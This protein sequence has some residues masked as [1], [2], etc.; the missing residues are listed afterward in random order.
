MTIK[1]QLEIEERSPGDVRITLQAPPAD[2][3]ETDNETKIL[4]AFMALGECL[5]DPEVSPKLG[6][7][8]TP[9]IHSIVLG[10]EGEN[11]ASQS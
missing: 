1:V 8:L 6:E 2:T 7:L 11:H 5:Q 4:L 9:K 10:T 3:N